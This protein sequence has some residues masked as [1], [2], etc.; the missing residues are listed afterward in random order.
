MTPKPVGQSLTYPCPHKHTGDWCGG[1]A[2]LMNNVYECQ[3]CYSTWN[4]NG[5]P[6]SK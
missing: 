3:R 5:E 1:I 2:A 4:L 6:T